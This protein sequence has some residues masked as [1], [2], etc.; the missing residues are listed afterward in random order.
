VVPK[1]DKEGM[2]VH[3]PVS[4]LQGIVDHA[5]EGKPNEVCGLIAGRNGYPVKLYRT[6]NSDPTPRV[7]YNVEPGELLNALREIEDN[8]WKLLAI[9]HSHPESEAYPSG[10]D[11]SLSYYPEAIYI[12]ASLVDEQ[13]PVVRAFRIVDHK[14]TELPLVVDQEV[15]EPRAGS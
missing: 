5:R 1:E 3:L 4:Y 7:R 11:V 13:S 14:I 2:V 9:Y 15:G 12:I 8:G 10:T 6:T